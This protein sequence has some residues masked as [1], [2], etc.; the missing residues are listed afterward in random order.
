MITVL[1]YSFR[2]N[3]ACDT[4]F[5]V[6]YMEKGPYSSKKSEEKQKK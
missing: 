3:P 6:E 5:T 2:R 4:G 1:L